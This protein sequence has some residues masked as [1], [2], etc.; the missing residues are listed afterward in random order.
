MENNLRASKAA[1]YLGI[2]E[3]TLWRFTR[4]GKIASIKLSDRI[5]VWSKDE[6]DRFVA[7]KTANAA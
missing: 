2:G 5:T 1:K 7:S 6:L 4:E 3:S